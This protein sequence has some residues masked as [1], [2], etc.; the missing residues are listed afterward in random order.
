MK[1]LIKKTD[2]SANAVT[3]TRAG[4]DTIEGASSKPLAKGYAS[5]TL[6]S[7]GTNEWYIQ[8]NAK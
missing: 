5:L 1:A 7:N 2:S 8:S 4:S 6:I 3:V